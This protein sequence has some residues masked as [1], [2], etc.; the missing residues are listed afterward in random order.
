MSYDFN[1]D[2]ADYRRLKEK[3]TELQTE[4]DS[5][6]FEL[7]GVNTGHIVD[8]LIASRVGPGIPSY[9]A[10]PTSTDYDDLETLDGLTS[11]NIELTGD[12]KFIRS[13]ILANTDPLAFGITATSIPAN[14]EIEFHLI[15]EQDSTGGRE[16]ATPS[17]TKFPNGSVLNEI[18]NKTAGSITVFDFAT[19]DVG[20][21]W[22]LR[23]GGSGNTGISLVNTGDTGLE[24]AALD[25]SVLKIKKLITGDSI[26]LS[27]AG[28]GN[29]QLKIAVNKITFDK[30]SPQPDYTD[31]VL[32]SFINNDGDISIRWQS[33]SSGI[34]DR[35]ITGTKIALSTIEAGNIKS[36]TITG[37]E[38]AV[39]TIGTGHFLPALRTL[40]DDAIIGTAKVT[41]GGTNITSYNKG[42]ILYA[43]SSTSESLA[44]LSVGTD[45]D[46]YVLTLSN[47]VPIWKIVSAS[48]TIPDRSITGTKIAL[49]TIAKDNLKTGIV[50][51]TILSLGAV[52]EGNLSTALQTKINDAATGAIAESRIPG[53][54][55]SKITSGT[56]D[57]AR[58]PGLPAIVITSGVFSSSRIPTTLSGARTFSDTVSFSNNVNLGNTSSDTIYI[59][60]RVGQSIVPSADDNYSL[61]EANLQWKNL[62]ID[63]L[64]YIDNI[65]MQSGPQIKKITSSTTLS[66]NSDD[67]LPTEKAVKA[68]VDNNSGGSFN[69]TA[70][71]SDL[72]PDGNRTRDLGNSSK[73]WDNAFF[74]DVVI[75]DDIEINGDLNHDGTKIGF[76]GNTPISGKTWLL[77]SS[78]NDYR[79]TPSSSNLIF[80]SNNFILL[81]RAFYT[82]VKDLREQGILK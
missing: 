80:N 63:G 75:N 31:Y 8:S 50:D 47:G 6:P 74:D 61:G 55:A 27:L 23:G 57:F 62:Y 44:V 1:D 68:Y 12:K 79:Q 52:F 14:R 3:L 30:L 36:S 72:I 4:I 38:I 29:S 64:A 20:V 10:N 25:G 11:V 5:I 37:T 33:P 15:L 48:S 58:I 7:E 45:P 66:G 73:Y 53:L 70:I 19:Y 2:S 35:S 22:I 51:N 13:A 60:G 40:I 34:S 77:G 28:T 67:T 24:L 16:L 39:N 78:V 43:S 18:L 59:K 71:N 56:L 41:D 54:P 82:L 81:S 17:S 49:S 69:P 76:R 9:M 65:I 32:S 21:T 42:D 26:A 46:G